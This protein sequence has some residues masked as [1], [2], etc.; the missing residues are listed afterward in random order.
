MFN[1]VDVMLEN[2]VDTAKLVLE[3]VVLNNGLDVE[4]TNG[5]EIGTLVLAE[6]L[7]IA[8]LEVELKNGVETGTLVFEAVVFN[9]GLDVTLEN[10][11]VAKLVLAALVVALILGVLLELATLS[12][13]QCNSLVVVVSTVWLGP[14]LLNRY[15]PSLLSSGMSVV[16]VCTKVLHDIL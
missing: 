10:V 3:T 14:A 2:G 4:F 15:I 5:V 1:G 8:G 16:I 11:G 9:I 7:F 13:R 6:V 12:A